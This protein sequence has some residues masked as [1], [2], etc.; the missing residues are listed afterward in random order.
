MISYHRARLTISIG[1]LLLASGTVSCQPPKEE[2][3]LGERP[4]V[5]QHRRPLLILGIDGGE[6]KV[7]RRM[8]EQGRLPHLKALS[9]KGVTASLGT[10]YTMSPV[11]WTTIATGLRPEEHGI[12]DF[13]VSTPNGNVPVSSSLRRVP[14]LWNMLSRAGRKVAV[15]GWWASWPAEE[16]NG[17]VVSDRA[18]KDLDHRVYP[19]EYLPQL[20]R[21]I[22][23]AD[24][25]P[26]PFEPTGSSRRQDQ[27]IAQIARQVVTEDYDLILAYLRGIDI[28]SHR[29]WKYFEP[30]RFPELRISQRELS[31]NEHRI[32]KEYE[33]VDQTLGSWLAA[34]EPEPNVLVISD[35]GFRAHSEEV[36]RLVLDF[37]LLLERLGFLVRVDG[38]IDFERTE[39]FT[40]ESADYRLVKN[41]RFAFAGRPEGGKVPPELAQSI[42]QRLEEE[43]GRI[44]YSNGEPTFWVRDPRRKESR[45]GIDF[46]VKVSQRTTNLDLLYDGDPEP[47]RGILREISRLSGDHT[48]HTHGVF[49]A[50]GPDI[51]PTANVEGIRIHDIAPTILYALG[52]PVGENFAGQPWMNLFSEDFRKANPLRT[53]KAWEVSR[54][55]TAVTSSA[56]EEIIRELKALGYL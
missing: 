55:G 1:L 2:G 6:W 34:A 3:A 20:Q 51:D 33:A 21:L 11:I 23:Q 44:T 17:L 46:A 25:A 39:L 16:V 49:F 45:R 53:V 32:P 35:H 52:L 7:I 18:L 27:L 36:I 28:A 43:L 22:S 31:A 15:L 4:K 12:E 19:P 30:E 26:N 48:T 29:F 8:W 38:K 10:S 24:D 41:L 40:F 37:D 56:D 14:A 50:A 54:E 47:L 42:R 13:V 5:T 9:E